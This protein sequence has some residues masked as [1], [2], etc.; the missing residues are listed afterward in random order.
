MNFLA[1]AYLSFQHPQI[2]AGNMI[3]DF[4][5]GAEKNRYANDVRQGIML[6]REIDSFT[7]AHPS[8]KKAKEIFRPYYRLYSGALIDVLYDHF[9]ANDKKI[10]DDASLKQFCHD[11]YHTLEEQVTELPDRFVQVL[12]YMKTEDW[13]YNYKYDW[14]IE[15]S[16]KG[17]VRRA[18]YLSDSH[19]AYTLFLNNY[20]SLQHCYEEF[21]PDVKQFAKHRF[22]ELLT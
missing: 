17:V 8:T 15:K 9:L 11:V 12:A 6:H 2:L 22:E 21:F 7:D 18:T 10:F 5:K 4:V 14:G 3:S 13:L 19:T 20:L 16:L 1:H